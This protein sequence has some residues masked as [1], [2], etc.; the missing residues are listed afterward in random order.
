MVHSHTLNREG[1]MPRKPRFYLPGFPVHVVQRGNN[2]QSIFFDDSD[3]KVYIGWLKESLV[4]YDCIL[5]AYVLMTN[6]V[7]LLVTP[8]E[9]ESTGRMMQYIGRRYV[10]Y[11]N[12]EYKRSGTLWEGRYKSSL[13]QA[14]SYLLACMRYIE[15]NPVRAGI[16]KTASAYRWSSYHCNAMGQDEELITAHPLYLSLGRNKQSRIYAYQ[17]LFKVHM[18]DNITD[19]I[20]AAWQTGTPLGGD[21][22]KAQIEKAL[23]TK[24]GYARRGR[25]KRALQIE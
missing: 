12:H 7:H 15:L 3:Y 14:E 9:K 18:A 16:V 6:H 24:V 23:N 13:V 11:I 20:R 8:Q 25:P 5:H 22:F 2:R 17:N 1:Q 21:R 19:Q 4:K 10:S